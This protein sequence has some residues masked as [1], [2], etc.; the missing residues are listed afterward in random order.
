[1]FYL[2]IP[3]LFQQEVGLNDTLLFFL[4]IVFKDKNFNF[5]NFLNWGIAYIK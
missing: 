1:M 5:F 4:K 2:I 3:K